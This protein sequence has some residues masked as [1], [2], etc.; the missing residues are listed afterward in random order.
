MANYTLKFQLLD[1]QGRSK[2]TQVLI[3]AADEAALLTAAATYSTTLQALTKCGI[4]Q[5]TYSNTVV[6]GNTPAAASNVD[7]GASFRFASPLLI[8]P[9][10]A[11][12]DPVE[13]IKDGSGGIDLADALITAWFA[14]YNPGGARLNRNT[15]TQPTS[16]IKGTLDK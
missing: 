4:V 15:F 1:E 11:L 13:A 7:A 8:D 9:T 6:V 10:F 14:L 16:I 3:T 12:V 5:Y 2:S